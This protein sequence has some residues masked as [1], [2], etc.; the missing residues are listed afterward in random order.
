MLEPEHFAK[1]MS[2]SSRVM[3]RHGTTNIST[4]FFL[5]WISAVEEATSAEQQQIDSITTDFGEMEIV[6][7]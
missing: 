6:V 7:D 1:M 5:R 4:E 3:K 2:K